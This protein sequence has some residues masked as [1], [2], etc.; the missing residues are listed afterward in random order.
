MTKRVQIQN[1][2]SFSTYHAKFSPSIQGKV[3]LWDWPGL[4]DLLK[5]VP[6]CKIEDQVIASPIQK[7]NP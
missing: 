4:Q 5:G 1:L 3:N 7:R 2:H 6:Y